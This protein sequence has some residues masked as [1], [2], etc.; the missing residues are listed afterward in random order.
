M[1]LTKTGVDIEGTVTFVEELCNDDGTWL[2][3]GME[4][5]KEWCHDHHAEAWCLQYNQ[6]LGRTLLFP[7]DGGQ[8]APPEAPEAAQASSKEAE[9]STAVEP[10][11]VRIKQHHKDE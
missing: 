7:I 4:S 10:K 11:T 9:D 8:P 2:R 6:H 3:L 5:V 1:Y